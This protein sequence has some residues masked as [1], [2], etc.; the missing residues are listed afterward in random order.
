MKRSEINSIIKRFESQIQTYK[1]NSKLTSKKK[2]TK[3]TVFDVTPLSGMSMILILGIII[4]S[5]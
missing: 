2:K 3:S 4:I 5:E 1:Y